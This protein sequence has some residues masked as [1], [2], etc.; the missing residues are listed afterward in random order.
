MGQNTNEQPATRRQVAS[1]NR[2][3][4]VANLAAAYYYFTPGC[5]LHDVLFYYG[6]AALSIEVAVAVLIVTIELALADWGSR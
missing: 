4:F 3:V 6:V 2:A 5:T 1:L